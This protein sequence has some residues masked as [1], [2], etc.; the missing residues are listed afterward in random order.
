MKTYFYADDKKYAED[1]CRG[2]Q[3]A[4][5]KFIPQYY[6]ISYWIAKK[7]HGTKNYQEF[8]EIPLNDGKSVQADDKMLDTMTWL[9]TKAVKATCNYAGNKKA[10]LDTYIKSVINGQWTFNDWLKKEYGNTDYIPKFLKKEQEVYQKI[11]IALRRKKEVGLIAKE[12]ELSIDETQNIISEIKYLLYKNGKGHYLANNLIQVDP[13]DNDGEKIEVGDMED[14]DAIQPSISTEANQI[15]IKLKNV[16]KELEKRDQRLLGLYW[17]EGMSVS[18]ILEYIQYEDELDDFQNI[19]I[20]DDKSFYN[21]I[22]SICQTCI[23]NIKENYSDFY[24]S[25]D[26]DISKIKNGLKVIINDY[27][28]N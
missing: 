14:K 25:Y 21:Y 3:P 6:D 26:L 5:N 17:G 22:T 23:K 24:H 8:F 4:R 15:F 28:L 7:W 2:Y 11:F 12:F 19:D 13:T 16:Y 20:Y 10:T 1:V 18:K 9:L 27:E